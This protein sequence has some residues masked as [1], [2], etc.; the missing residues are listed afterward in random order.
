[1]EPP[2][3]T[4]TP[5]PIPLKRKASKELSP[6]SDDPPDKGEQETEEQPTQGPQPQSDL[7]RRRSQRLEKKK[8]KTK[9]LPPNPKRQAQELDRARKAINLDLQGVKPP[10]DV[11]MTPVVDIVESQPTAKQ[12][13]PVVSTLV[14]DIIA[15][16][17]LPPS[18][19][20]N[21]EFFA[22]EFH[23]F[24]L[25]LDKRIPK[26]Q[27]DL[28]EICYQYYEHCGPGD[29]QTA[30]IDYNA[31][32]V[33]LMFLNQQGVQNAQTWVTPWGTPLNILIAA[34]ARQNK[35]LSF[36][37]NFTARV[38]NFNRYDTEQSLAE[39]ITRLTGVAIQSTLIIGDQY[40]TAL[41]SVASQIDL[42]KIVRQRRVLVHNHL[43][44]ITP[45]G[46]FRAAV[47]YTRNLPRQATPDNVEA[48]LKSWML[49]PMRVVVPRAKSGLALGYGFI[50]YKSAT[51]AEALIKLSETKHINQRFLIFEKARRKKKKQGPGRK[52]SGPIISPP[53]GPK[54]LLPPVP[55]P[56]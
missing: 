16:K 30:N 13:R 6:V 19:R 24:Y 1:M 47:V 15:G 10:E 39:A 49:P 29:E 38:A 3:P 40:K 2:T 20:G 33:E 7:S 56:P 34:K 35:Q 52:H 31:G 42:N 43:V 46:N 51:D 5:P 18:P 26:E 53:T 11:R 9:K 32:I 36:V 23:T 25:V 55:S 12:K 50:F 45:Q 28:Q 54:S 14:A 48:M 4:P 41:I 37:A 17:G 27:W 44:R 8:K 21:A 22:D